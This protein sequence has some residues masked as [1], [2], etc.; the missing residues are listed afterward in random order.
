MNFDTS[1]GEFSGKAPF[2][3]V[4]TSYFFYVHS[5]S[6]EF[7]GTKVKLMAINVK[8]WPS[9]IVIAAVGVLFS[10]SAFSAIIVLSRYFGAGTSPQSI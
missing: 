2:V 4:D 5:Q 7:T 8:S 1:S 3:D 10:S 6:P 9:I